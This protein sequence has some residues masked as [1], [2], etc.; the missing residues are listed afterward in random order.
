MLAGANAVA[1]SVTPSRFLEENYFTGAIKP[2][3]A[4]ANYSIN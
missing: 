3:Q 2:Y 1:G 4:Q